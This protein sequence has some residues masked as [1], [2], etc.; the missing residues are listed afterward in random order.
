MHTEIL[1]NLPSQLAQINCKDSVLLFYCSRNDKL[2]PQ[3]RLV[4]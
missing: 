4:P 1:I 2:V 3:T